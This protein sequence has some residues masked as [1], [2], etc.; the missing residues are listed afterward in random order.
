[1]KKAMRQSYEYLW[2]M[3]DDTF[4]CQDAAER[5]YD[6]AGIL[7]N[8]FG[9]LAST[10]FF[11]ENELCEMNRPGVSNKWYSMEKYQYMKAGLINIQYASFVSLFL[12][13][14][15]VEQ[16]GLPLKEFF[17]WND[18]YEYT[19]RIS[20]LYDN[21]L[22][23]NSVVEHKMKLNQT[24]D[25]LTDHSERIARYFYNYRNGFYVA[26][27]DGKKAVVR[28]ILGSIMI[29]GK[30]IFGQSGLKGRK[31]WIVLKGLVA[32]MVFRPQVEYIKRGV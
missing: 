18:D 21:Y 27:R 25:I 6:A 14:E 2:L 16:I 24:T 12:R 7:K 10:V 30:I 19:T 11:N 1:I 4:V 5:L 8:R 23:C 29:L 15:V 22:V 28:Y 17:I 32:G 9:F 3:D 13:T 20:K 31:C 26:K